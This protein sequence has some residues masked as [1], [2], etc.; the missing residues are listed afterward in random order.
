MKFGQVMS[1]Y[2]TKKNYEK[3][4]Q[5]FITGLCLLYK[6]FGKICFVFHAWAF[7]NI[8]TFE[9]LKSQILIIS[10]MK[11]LLKWNEKRFSLFHKCSFLDIQNKLAKMY[12]TQSLSFVNLSL[13]WK[14]YFHIWLQNKGEI[15]I[16]SEYYNQFG[17]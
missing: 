7:D 8:M 11:K 12:W 5:K 16:W 9:Y 3:I 1:Y 15:P 2:K 10:R 4:W 13:T 14:L 17:I 6:L